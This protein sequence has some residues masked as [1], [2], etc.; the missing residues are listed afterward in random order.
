M[1]RLTSKETKEQVDALI[2]DPRSLY[3]G[4]IVN[5]R[6]RSKTSEVPYSEIVAKR[7]LHVHHLPDLLRKLPKVPHGQLVRPLDHD[8]T[9]LDPTILGIEQE[10]RVAVALYNHKTLGSLGKV[11]DYLVPITYDDKH[12]GTIDLVSF[13]ASTSTLYLIGYAF[14]ERR[15]DTLLRCVLEIATLANSVDDFRFA[16]MYEKTL[17]DEQGNAIRPQDVKVAPAILLLEGSYQ[18]R[19]ISVLRR[20]PHVADLVQELDVRMYVIGIELQLRDKPR[21]NRK[22]AIHPYRPVLNYVPVLRE[23]TIPTI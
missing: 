17:L 19:S 5:R 12:V 23:R 22:S 1:E 4:G 18:D 15:R 11:L 16:R 2:A 7:L 3:K 13:D 10:D 14:Q 6:G 9:T 20:M 21:F 8:G